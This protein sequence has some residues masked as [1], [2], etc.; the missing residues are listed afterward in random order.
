MAPFVRDPTRS[1][2]LPVGGVRYAPL[3]AAG[4][5]V[6]SVLM[7]QAQQQK[8]PDPGRRQTMTRDNEPVAQGPV[9]EACGACGLAAGTV[10]RGRRALQGIGA[11]EL[12]RCLR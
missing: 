2:Q 11:A 6:R 12:D 8:C 1:T 4:T 3:G 9:S 5:V 7:P 10:E